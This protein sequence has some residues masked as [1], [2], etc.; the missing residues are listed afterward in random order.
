MLKVHRFAVSIIIVLFLSVAASQLESRDR[1][2]PALDDS[3]DLAGKRTDSTQFFLMQ[4]DVIEYSPAGERVKIDYY[5]LL[6]KCI[7]LR[8]EEMEGYQYKCGQFSL[9]HGED[10]EISIPSLE[11]LEYIWVSNVDSSGQVFGI[12]HSRFE[13]LEDSQ[14]SGLAP[15]KSYLVYNAFIDFHSFCDLFAEPSDDGRGIQDLT[16]VGQKIVHSAAYSRPP[17]NLG[18]IILDGSYFEN[19]EITLEF[20][21]ISRIDGHPC[22]LVEYDSGQSSYRM[23]MEPVPGMQIETGG[24]S[25]Y[26]G[27]IY[28]DL[29]TNWVR[30]VTMN[31]F[32][33]SE[34]ELP[35]GRGRI[36]SVVERSI[37]I[38]NISE[39][40][41]TELL[42]SGGPHH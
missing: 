30:R 39:E 32:V 35:M 27:D 38:R 42:E 10:G 2:F 14:G 6:L 40:E 16:A 5:K 33:V 21:G 9:N 20:K 7:P 3:Y 15:D 17:V 11:N 18:K 41:W 36:N 23:F 34:T 25:H 1:L 24:S 22:A 8:D 26:M 13:G 31:E 28:K 37:L 29:N 4:T 19:G 12:D